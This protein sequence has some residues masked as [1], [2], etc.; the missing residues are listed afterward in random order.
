LPATLLPSAVFFFQA[1]A[2][3]RD[4]HVTGVQTCALPISPWGMA[5]TGHLPIRYRW[6]AAFGLPTSARRG[7][8]RAASPWVVPS[9]AGEP[10]FKI[11]RASCR[12][13]VLLLLRPVAARR[14][15]APDD[16]RPHSRH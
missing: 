12:E 4:F 3:I 15:N 16:R 11:G 8:T 7:V 1:E 13:Q 10:M 14:N 9:T 6:R 5:V 2:G